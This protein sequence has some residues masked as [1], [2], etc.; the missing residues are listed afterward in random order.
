[1]GRTEEKNLRLTVALMTS[2]LKLVSDLIKELDLLS[3]KAAEKKVLNDLH[4][5]LD[6]GEKGYVIS[7][8]DKVNHESIKQKLTDARIPFA[9]LSDKKSSQTH[10]IVA[11][12]DKEKVQG[13]IDK[14]FNEKASQMDSKKL[15]ET[16]QGREIAKIELT[17]TQASI[18]E[19]KAENYNISFSSQQKENGKV[20][21]SAE[22]T[23]D[24]KNLAYY[25][26]HVSQG[27]EG[28]LQDLTVKNNNT[29]KS[30]IEETVDKNKTC[31]FYSLDKPS[32]FIVATDH[33]CKI[34]ENNKLSKSIALSEDKTEAKKEIYDLT[35]NIAFGKCIPIN[36]ENL[37]NKSEILSEKK[38]EFELPDNLTQQHQHEEKMRLLVEMKMSMDNNSVNL[39]N[40]DDPECSFSEFFNNECVADEHCRQV[41]NDLDKLPSDE[42]KAITDYA[43]NLE[44][45][46]N[47]IDYS[48]DVSVAPLLADKAVIHETSI[49]ENIEEGSYD[50]YRENNDIS[51]DI[52]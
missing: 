11:E 31:H 8:D 1:M 50:S 16:F 44:N 29:V 9:C 36:E 35:K 2:A 5:K 39:S 48:L 4:N 28:Q 12:S 24:F 26:A 10:F 33:S 23:Q 30:A 13:Y 34:F 17:P 41:A 27:I 32:T 40:L 20:E 25:C 21:I 43:Q 52:L 14:C 46:E 3:D 45:A 7:V 37:Q 42:K 51:H 18:F 47:E 19:R 22:N 15:F 49:K 6:A 38:K